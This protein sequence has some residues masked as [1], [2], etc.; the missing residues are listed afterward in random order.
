MPLGSPSSQQPEDQHDPQVAAVFD[1]FEA[2]SNF[3]GLYNLLLTID[4]RTHPELY[5]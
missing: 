5:D 3:V 1:D 4:R 2:K